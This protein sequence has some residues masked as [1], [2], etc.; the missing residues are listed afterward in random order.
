MP[1]V[2]RA[3]IHAAPHPSRN[4]RAAMSTRNDQG[5]DAH[6]AS[7]V[8]AHRQQPRR[9]FRRKRAKDLMSINDDVES[10]PAISTRCCAT[11]IFSKSEMVLSH[12]ARPVVRESIAEAI[13][14]GALAHQQKPARIPRPACCTRDDPPTETKNMVLQSRNLLKSQ[15]P[16]QAGG[17][18]AVREKPRTL[19]QNSF[20]DGFSYSATLQLLPT[21]RYQLGVTD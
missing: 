15:R 20:A 18:A 11:A 14:S 12:A 10:I 5:A 2:A 8:R 7:G 6:H 16:E 13:K 9:G 1:T 4:S 3:Q 21:D 17:S 19:P